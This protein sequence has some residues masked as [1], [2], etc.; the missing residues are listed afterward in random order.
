MPAVASQC[1]TLPAS[2]GHS[3]SMINERALPSNINGLNVG[4]DENTMKN[5]M[6]R[7]SCPGRPRI[8]VRPQLL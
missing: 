5:T 8:R 6:F 1:Q 7:N 2:A 3:H 4:A